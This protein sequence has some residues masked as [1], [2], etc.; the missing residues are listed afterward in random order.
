MKVAG[1]IIFMVGLIMTVYTGFTLVTR[2]KVVDFGDLETTKDNHHSVSWQ[3]YVGIGVM[4]SVEQSSSLGGRNRS[5]PERIDN[6]KGR[7]NAIYK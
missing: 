7:S 4:V 5:P 1:I 2:E 6:T 3:P